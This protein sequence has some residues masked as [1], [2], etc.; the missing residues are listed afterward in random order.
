MTIRPFLVNGEWRTGEGTLEVR[1]PFDDSLV[2]ELG[3]PTDADVEEAAQVAHDTFHEA[4]RLPIHVRSEALDHI[5]RRL[6]EDIERN[7]KLIAP[8]IA[9]RDALQVSIVLTG[10]SVEYSLASR[11]RWA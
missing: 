5:S 9:R 10:R 7:A 11:R 4:V 8:A 3:V 6:A 2:E 1:S